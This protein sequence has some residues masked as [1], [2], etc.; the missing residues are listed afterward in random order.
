MSA[1]PAPA[2]AI[3]HVTRRAR[4]ATPAARRRLRALLGP[5]ADPDALAAALLRRA[6]VAVHFHPDRIAPWLPGAV[7][8]VE[9]LLAT[10]RYV[11]QFV[12]GLSAGGLM[13]FP[14]SGR[15]RWESAMF[16]GAYHRPGVR[17]QDRPVY[18]ALDLLRHADGPAPRFGSC[19][20]R[21]RPGV[22]DR[23]TLT[24][25][26]SHL[27]PTDVGAA[28]ELGPVLAGLLEEVAAGRLHL[29]APELDV[30][31]LVGLLLTP[32]EPPLLTGRLGRAMDEYVEVQVH[33]PLLLGED[34]DLVVA[35]PSFAG[36]P[37]EGALAALATRYG[38]GMAWHP[39]FALAVDEVPAGPRG[40]AV[41]ALA[42]RM[43]QRF[44]VDVVTAAAIG[45]A[46]RSLALDPGSW[47]DWAGW[48]GQPATLQHLK[49]L[50]H[51]LV[52]AGT[53]HST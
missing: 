13:P 14:G 41:P 1:P 24:V 4:N 45:T 10:G 51:V 30:R 53:P 11:S 39:G 52:I 23:S 16:G 36:T 12:T 33:G 22:V 46:A 42:Q 35:D 27:Q 21:L 31:A 19:H 20:L 37:V 38:F 5:E 49:Q 32:S 40:P 2:A 18:G 43:R 44:G 8:V 28:G 47:E 50:W 34:V 15:D 25:G 3:G 7:T 29:G 48:P 17:P 6:R 26:D 9:S